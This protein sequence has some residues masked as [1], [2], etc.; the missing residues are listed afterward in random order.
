LYE[1]KTRKNSLDKLGTLEFDEFWLTSSLLY[2][3]ATENEFLAKEDQK[4][5][6]LL[7]WEFGLISQ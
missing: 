7:K 6:F 3:I 4:F 2:L 1:S 5:E